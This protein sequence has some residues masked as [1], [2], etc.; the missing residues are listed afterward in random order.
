M[1]IE[2]KTLPGIPGE[3]YLYF[4]AKAPLP[5]TDIMGPFSTPFFVSKE[6]AERCI[7]RGMNVQVVDPKKSKAIIKPRKLQLK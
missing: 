3:V 1:L 7:R 5:G 4:Y 2:S 6:Y